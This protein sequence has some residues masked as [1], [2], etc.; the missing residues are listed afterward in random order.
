MFWA[1]EGTPMLP[2]VLAGILIGVVLG[3]RFTVLALIPAV[4]CAL[5]IAGGSV[6]APGAQ[7]FGLT[8]AE[9]ALLL[10][11]IQLGYFGGA[12]LRLALPRNTQRSAG[13]VTPGPDTNLRSRLPS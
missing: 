8:I 11:S 6:A 2:F 9:L 3:A 5:V 7:A 13:I 4:G 12:A 1:L 10:G